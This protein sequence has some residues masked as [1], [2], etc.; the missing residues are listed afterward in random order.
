MEA[1]GNNLVPAAISQGAEVTGNLDAVGCIKTRDSSS[2][3]ANTM[4]KTAR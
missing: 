3:E 2:S 4:R 1:K